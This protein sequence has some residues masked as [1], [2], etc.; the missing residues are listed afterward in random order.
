MGVV[1]VVELV[2]VLPTGSSILY[3]PT[4]GQPTARDIFLKLLRVMLAVY[5]ALA[6]VSEAFV[7]PTVSSPGYMY[8]FRRNKTTISTLTSLYFDHYFPSLISQELY[9]QHQQATVQH[10]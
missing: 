9:Q 6:G 1:R 3:S 2:G 10:R 8:R 4:F 7:D 5:R